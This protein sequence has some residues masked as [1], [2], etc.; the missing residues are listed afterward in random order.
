MKK[1][2][3]SIILVFVL[4]CLPLGSYLYLRQGF[5]FRK[6]LI[7]DLKTSTPLNNKPTERGNP[8]PLKGRCT[9][10]ALKDNQ[11]QQLN[12]YDQFK[13]AKGFQMAGSM[14]TTVVL[15]Y[16]LS[17]QQTADENLSR[18]YFQLDSISLMAL[19]SAFPVSNYIILDTLGMLRYKYEGNEN[20]MK[21]LAGHITVLLPLYK[22]K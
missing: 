2:F 20:D 6:N 9:V 5:S 14:D 18:N 12:L 4:I 7:N 10:V 16:M 13:D 11:Q 3:N 22:E 19:R 17:R 15:P 21:K 8:I 1:Y